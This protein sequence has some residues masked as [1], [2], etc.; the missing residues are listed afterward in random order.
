MR[1]C[2]EMS[3]PLH[4]KIEVD[5]E[6]RTGRR[7][8]RRRDLLWMKRKMMRLVGN[9]CSRSTLRDR[10]AESSSLPW[11]VG[12][13]MD[14]VSTAAAFHLHGHIYTS[15]YMYTVIKHG[16]FGLLLLYT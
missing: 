13:V 12:R 7:G 1:L 3:L 8:D 4:I 6:V 15:V 9:N 2:V 14:D 5:V 11:C 10:C 16:A